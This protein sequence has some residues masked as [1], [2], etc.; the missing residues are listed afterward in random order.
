MRR[1]RYFWVSGITPE[2]LCALS[3]T[4]WQWLCVTADIMWF[5]LSPGSEAD[6]GDCWALLCSPATAMTERKKSLSMMISGIFHTAWR[7]LSLCP[8]AHVSLTEKLGPRVQPEISSAWVCL[9]LRTIT[10]AHW[11]SVVWFQH[12]LLFFL[13]QNKYYTAFSTFWFVFSIL[14][15]FHSNWRTGICRDVTST[16]SVSNQVKLR[17]VIPAGCTGLCCLCSLWAK[18]N[19]TTSVICLGVQNIS[20]SVWS[21]SM[22]P[23]ECNCT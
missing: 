3:S 2:P 8:L 18:T 16:V 6:D 10:S 1:L 15:W 21:L 14:S 5:L 17:C 9:S 23:S 7:S 22:E 11:H 20:I 19:L 13:N 4:P 12:L